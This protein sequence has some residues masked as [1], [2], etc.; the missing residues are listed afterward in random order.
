MASALSSP[1]SLVGNGPLPKSPQLVSRISFLVT[2]W[3]KS[4]YPCGFLWYWGLTSASCPREAR[5]LPLSWF[6][7]AG[8][9]TL[10][11]NPFYFPLLESAFE[12]L[13]HGLLYNKSGC[14]FKTRGKTHYGFLHILRYNLIR[15]HSPRIA[16]LFN[17]H[18]RH[19][20][21][22]DYG[23]NCFFPYDVA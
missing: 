8:L 15:P 13:T 12:S 22:H 18:C 10:T 11:T 5:T 19:I 3:L 20:R 14:F 17:N 7:S 21:D 4:L 1:R 2:M 9:S 16:S 23:Y 6:P